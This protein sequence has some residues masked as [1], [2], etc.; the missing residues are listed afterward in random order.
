[1]WP[2]ERDTGAGTGT[3]GD[4]SSVLIYLGEVK[5]ARWGGVGKWR[6]GENN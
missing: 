2:E 4:K 5:R 1:M 6:G 3:Y